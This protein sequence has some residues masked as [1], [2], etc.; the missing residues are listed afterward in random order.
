VRTSVG[1]VP[2]WPNATA[3][4]G[5]RAVCASPAG[6]GRFYTG[7]SPRRVASPARRVSSAASGCAYQM[8]WMP[9]LVENAPTH[10]IRKCGAWCRA[11]PLRPA[12]PGAAVGQGV[13]GGRPQGPLPGLAPFGHMCGKNGPKTRRPTLLH[14][15]WLTNF[16]WLPVGSPSYQIMDIAVGGGRLSDDRSLPALVASTAAAQPMQARRVKK[17]P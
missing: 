5:R 17:R 16:G 15:Q 13:G 10:D 2:R 14:T 4:P 7:A 8:T 6:I 9:V 11:P 12:P 1:E 3:F